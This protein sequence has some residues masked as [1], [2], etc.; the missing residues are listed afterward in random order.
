M[1][2]LFVMT[3]IRDEICPPSRKV[4]QVPPDSSKN[5]NSGQNSI[6]GPTQSIEQTSRTTAHN[7][8]A[9]TEH[10]PPSFDSI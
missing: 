1:R 2:F 4:R 8:S 7:T 5:I 9:L 10:I 6:N 3:A